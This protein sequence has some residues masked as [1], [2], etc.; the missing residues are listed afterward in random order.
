MV[1]PKDVLL[2]SSVVCA[3]S[4]LALERKGRSMLALSILTLAALLVRLYAALLDPFLNLWDECFHALVAKNMLVEPFRPML[5]TEAA[6]PVSLH[7]TEAHIWLHKPPFFLWQIALSI[8]VFGPE[9]WAVRIPTVLWLTALVPVGYR[10]ALLLT[11]PRTAWISAL[12]LTFSYYLE[13]L[14]SGALGTDHNDAIFIAT[15]V[16]SWWALLE[17]W[18]DGRRR[19]A[20]LIGLFSACAVLTKWYVGLSVFLPWGVV[21][22]LRGFRRTALL[23]LLLGL[24]IML[25]IVGAWVAYIAWRFPVETAHEWSFKA[26]HMGQAMDAHTGGWEYHFEV[27]RDVLRPLTPW[28]VLPAYAW[29]VW[30]G[31]TMEH[32]IL[33][34]TLF[35]SVHAVF[36]IAQT[37]MLG[38][39]MVL[40]PLYII[41]VAHGM[42]ALVEW[43]IPVL[44]RPWVWVPASVVLAGSLLNLDQVHYRHSLSTPPAS[45]QRWRRQQLETLPILSALAER[46]NGMG[47]VAV[48]NVPALHHIQFMFLTGTEAWH[49]V[50]DQ[51]T[52]DRLLTKGYTVLVV[53]DGIPA[54]Q[55]PLGVQLIP[56][57]VLRFPSIGRP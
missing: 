48:F 29:L 43:V 16:C 14:T 56:D 45:D 47:P 54:D 49:R 46:T 18:H 1:G 28:T 24:C 41:A 26:S 50:P 31:R 12:L 7:W 15:V 5:H 34:S 13:E 25:T 33:L 10:I 6:M 30:K 35:V 20:L 52:V 57:S 39:T 9:P 51:A 55:F 27:I 36:A 17:L 22:V 4:A 19:W 42:L 38:Y 40:F 53:Q 37:K 3:L 44:Y 32:R 2:V 23:D 8:G 11:N 21:V